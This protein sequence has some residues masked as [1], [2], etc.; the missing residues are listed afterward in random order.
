METQRRQEEDDLRRECG[1]KGS[2]SVVQLRRSRI[3]AVAAPGML[4]LVIVSW[5]AKLFN[6][7]F[8]AFQMQAL[9]TSHRVHN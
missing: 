3:A 4:L 9:M 6:F 5:I 8:F 7:P 1:E 2:V